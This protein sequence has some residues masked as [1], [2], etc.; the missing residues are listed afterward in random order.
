[1]RTDAEVRENLNKKEF[2]FDPRIDS[3]KETRVIGSALI[4]C[5]LA[6]NV[7]QTLY[8]KYVPL[9]YTNV[10]VASHEPPKK[11]IFKRAKFERQIKKDELY[12]L[13]G[14]LIG[15]AEA[16]GSFAMQAVGHTVIN[17]MKLRYM[18]A[19]SIKSVVLAPSQYSCWQLRKQYIESSAKRRTMQWRRAEA[20]A[21]KLLTQQYETDPTG[22]SIDYHARYVKPKWAK[23]YKISFEYGSHIFYI[24]PNFD[25]SRIRT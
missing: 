17:R 5:V 11:I 18:G 20:I 6:I 3:F 9:E 19:S 7:A 15:E 12:Y 21:R 13:T 22:G 24:R 10:V 23:K 1:M 25:Y 8:D 16:E 2:G 14:T 4:A